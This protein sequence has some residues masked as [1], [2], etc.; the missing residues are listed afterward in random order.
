[1]SYSNIF[2]G[3]VGVVAVSGFLGG[4]SDGYHAG[5]CVSSRVTSYDKNVIDYRNKCGIG[6]NV[7]VCSNQ[8][9]TEFFS[10][11]DGKDRT[12]C[13]RKYVKA[14]GYIDNFYGASENSSFLRKAVSTT[15]LRIGACKPP[16]K[17]NFTSDGKVSCPSPAS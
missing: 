6:I 3:A 14:G 2:W 15:N 4:E 16:V 5:N 9:A 10:I 1:M 17:P 7:I 12:S 8:A 11:F 13:Q